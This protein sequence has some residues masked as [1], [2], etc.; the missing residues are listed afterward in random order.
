MTIT[1]LVD[2]Q[3]DTEEVRLWF[4]SDFE[5]MIKNLQVAGLKI[6]DLTIEKCREIAEK[7]KLQALYY[8]H[9]AHTNSTY[10]D[11]KE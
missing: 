5:E 2:F 10:A 7:A 3:N 11:F 8:S 4:K 9:E 1:E 6:S